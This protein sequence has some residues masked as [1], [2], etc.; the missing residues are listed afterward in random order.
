MRLEL[1]PPALDIRKEPPTLPG[2]PPVGRLDWITLLESIRAIHSMLQVAAVAQ[3]LGY[4]A[5]RARPNSSSFSNERRNFAASVPYGVNWIFAFSTFTIPSSSSRCTQVT[6]KLGNRERLAASSKSEIGP[7]SI[8][9]RST[10][11]SSLGRARS[12]SNSSFDNSA[13][14][15]LRVAPNQI[16]PISSFNSK[17]E[18]CSRHPTAKLPSRPCRHKRE[19][20]LRVHFL[21][22]NMGY[23]NAKST[24]RNLV[25][26]FRAFLYIETSPI[27]IG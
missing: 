10:L 23:Q 8:R 15:F 2:P 25:H 13:I 20:P 26:S 22:M 12:S 16:E 5:A 21:T 7:R 24:P 4:M 27:H 9:P 19:P 3:L 18:C 14:S 1:L 11:L 6:T 17:G